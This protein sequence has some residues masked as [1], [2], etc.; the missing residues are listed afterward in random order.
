MYAGVALFKAGMLRTL[1]ERSG[2]S[3]TAGNHLAQFIPKVE[4]REIDVIRE[5][6]EDQYVHSM[7]DGTSRLGELMNNVL[8]YCDTDFTLHQRLVLLITYEKHLTGVQI[9]KML[10]V[11]YLTTFKLQIERLIGFGRDSAAVNGVGVRSL[12]VTFTY[13]EDVLCLCHTLMNVG[14]HIQLATLDEFLSKWIQI[15]YGGSSAAHKA[16][17]KRMI[18]ISVVGHSTVRWYCEGEIIIQNAK[19]F[20]SLHPFLTQLVNDG[21]CPTLAPA[22]LEIL[23]SNERLLKLQHAA[24][25]DIESIISVTYEMEGDGLP[26]TINNFD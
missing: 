18:D 13:A 16:A 3:C 22:A 19:H 2:H 12:T 10:T 20:P 11:L 26:Q 1:L 24:I 15:I 14:K 9:S 6:I 17:W 4:Q 25:M 7:F 5:E 23:N 8:R 21:N